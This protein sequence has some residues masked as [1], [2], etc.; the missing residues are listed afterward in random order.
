MSVED[1]PGISTRASFDE[2]AQGGRLQ[3]RRPLVLMAYRFTRNRLAVLALI[4]ILVLILVTLATPYLPLKDPLHIE[5]HDRF[6][7]PFTNPN[8]LL[9]TD[10]LGRDMLSRLLWAGRISLVVGVSAMLVTITVGAAVGAVA[11][12]YGGWRDSL[13]MR[14]VDV[15]MCFPS[16]YLLLAVAAFIKPTVVTI[17]LI[18]GATAW[19][20]VARIVRNQFLAL[21]GQDFILATECIGVPPRQVMLRHLLPNGIA[22]LVVAATLNV[23]LA[24]LLESYISFLGFGIQP[25]A[26]SWG[27]MLNNAQSYFVSAPWVAIFPGLMITLVVTSFNF[28]GDGLRDALD[29]RTIM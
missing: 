23:A 24:V 19:M 15:M 10:E 5:I 4:T 17:S 9:G 18:I 14:A 1:Q 26:A 6:T 2:S 21:K 12:Q 25:P 13:L 16:V 11:A 27:N 20:A 28:L 7:P 8:Y 3:S 29:P 22:P